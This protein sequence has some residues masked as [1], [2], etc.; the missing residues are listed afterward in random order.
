MLIAILAPVLV[1]SQQVTISG[2]VMEKKS[3]ER[4]IGATVFIPERNIG[5]TTNAYGFYSITTKAENVRLVASYVGY[6]SSSFQL[7]LQQN[8]SLNIELDLAKDMKEVVVT[9][10]TRAHANEQYRFADTNH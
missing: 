1:F 8:T 5:T 7:N 2:Y 4:L 9:S 3:G 6:A 10:N